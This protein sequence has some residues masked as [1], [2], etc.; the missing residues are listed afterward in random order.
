MMRE[1]SGASD[2]YAGR[3]PPTRWSLVLAAG[4]AADDTRAREALGQLCQIYWF[5]LYAFARRRGH[6]PEDAQDLTQG[7]LAHVLKHHAVAKSSS[8]KGR[9]RT[10]LLAAFKNFLTNEGE[11]IQAQKRGGGQVFLPLDADVTEARYAWELANHITPDKIYERQ[12]ALTLLDW[13]M[14]RLRAEQKGRKRLA[15]FDA[16][17]QH[18]MGDQDAPS[19]ADLAVQLGM[20]GA[21]LRMAVLRLRRR[22]RELLEEEIAQTVASPEEA[23]AEL[24]HLFRVFAGP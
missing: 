19:C 14:A 1:V 20:T 9:F 6:R 21:A 5:P 7:F 15:Q 22:Y 13:V 16:L 23:S 3:F 11:R 24:Q 10:F 17:K 12:W 4:D 18:L 2:A 8:D